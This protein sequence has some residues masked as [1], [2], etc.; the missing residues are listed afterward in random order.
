MRSNPIKEQL[1]TIPIPPELGHRS[2]LGVRQAAAERQAINPSARRQTK[3][4]IAA[5]S[6]ALVLF[7]LTTMFADH[8]RVWSA[9]QK[10]LQFVPGIGIVKEE[11]SP[12]ERYVMNQP[13]TVEVGAGSI[14]I[15]GFMSDDEMT[16]ITMAGK[17]APR[18]KDITLVNERGE[19]FKLNASTAS[20]GQSQWTSG[21]W[22]IGKLDVSGQVTLIFPLDPVVKV[23]IVLAKAE[24]FAS[25]TELGETAS[26][27]GVSITAITDRIGGK[28]RVSLVSRHSKD[29]DVSD[30]G[31]YG[32]YMHEESQKLQVTD[33]SGKKLAIEKIPG[34]SSPASEFFF[35]APEAMAESS[36]TLTIP[37]ISVRY[38]DE[39]RIELPTETDEHLNQTFKIAGFPVMI[40]KVEHVMENKLRVYMDLYYNEQTTESLVN[41]SIDGLSHMAKLDE[42]TGAIE[43]IEFEMKDRGS[44]KVSL[45]L[46]QPGVVMRGPW[47]F[48]LQSS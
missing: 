35:P 17:D 19:Q 21:F 8:S 22:H 14:L 13:V 7:M 10:A 44:K 36:Y 15:T 37:E 39:I 31:I 23:P 48:L 5:M 18:V 12:V 41:F 24:T 46:V 16:Y 1:E 11:D 26:V 40:T 6:A 38:K 34:V 32:V 28:T 47:Q 25:Y 4:I 29:F 20:W 2:L 27:N 3:R 9:I 43:Y 42:K 30:Y 45:K 33:T